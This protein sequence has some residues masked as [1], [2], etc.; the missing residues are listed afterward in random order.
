MEPFISPSQYHFI[1]F[2]V[3]KLVNGYANSHDNDVRKALK[4]IVS[5]NVQHEW[6]H[7]TAEQNELMEPITEIEDKE[8]A[9]IFLAQIKS[10]VIPFNVTDK[11]IIKLFPKVKKLKVPSFEEVDMRDISYLSWIDKGTLEKYIV[12]RRDDKLIGIKGSFTRSNQKGIC[13][14]CNQYGDLG[15]FL[16]EK[17]GRIQGSMMKRGNYI[18]SDSQICNENLMSLD[19]LYT[20]VERLKR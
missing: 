6:P 17:K 16:A 15:M 12:T 2:Q 10:Y 13:S 8:K 3:K 18:C 7:L 11:Q 9:D 19:K 20:F 1:R 5:E 14:L 4:S